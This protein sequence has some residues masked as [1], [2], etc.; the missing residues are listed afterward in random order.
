MK[1]QMYA[2]GIPG[3]P[4]YYPA[5]TSAQIQLQDGNSYI[6]RVHGLMDGSFEIWV[7]GTGINVSPPTPR[8][9]HGD[10]LVQFL[11]RT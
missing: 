9:Y 4:L 2:D 10:F 8:S 6:M 7:R 5:F 11:V 1:I 3:Q